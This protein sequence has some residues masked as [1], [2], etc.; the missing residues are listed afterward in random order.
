ML[1]KHLLTACAMLV[2]CATGANAQ[3]WPGKIIGTWRGVSNQSPIVLT[4]STQSAGGKCDYI[5][6]NIK[7]VNGRFT[8]P[9]D[10]YYCPSSGA[11]Q[12]LRYGT[13]GNVAFQVYNGYVSQTMPPAGEKILM[14]GSFG[15]YS[16]SY[17]PLGQYGFSLTK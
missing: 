17:G 1:N 14:G 10:G 6:G 2:A 8:G 16:L 3:A 12:F 5:S 13:G 11:L 4:V 9:M 15:Q 7:D